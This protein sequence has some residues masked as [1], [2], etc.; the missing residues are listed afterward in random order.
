MSYHTMSSTRTQN[1]LCTAGTPISSFAHCPISFRLLPSSVA[2]F[3][4]IEVFLRYSNHVSVAE[5]SDTY[6]I[7]HW[8]IIWS[9]YRKLV[10]SFDVLSKNLN[11]DLKSLS[12]WL[13][14]NKLS[15]NILN[16]DLFK[17]YR[18]EVTIDRSFKFNLDRKSLSPSQSVKYLFKYY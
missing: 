18:N 14:A 1:H 9:S 11:K 3:V 8:R 12:Q 17:F 2:T 7:H 10:L 4:L 13:K 15:L 16:T 6:G 5:W